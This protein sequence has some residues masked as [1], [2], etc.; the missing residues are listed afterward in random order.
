[1]KLGQ[2]AGL[3]LKT[4]KHFQRVEKGFRMVLYCVGMT[5]QEIN[6]VL[7]AKGPYAQITNWMH[8]EMQHAYKEPPQQSRSFHNDLVLLV[9][10]E[11]D[12]QHQETLS[13]TLEQH[14]A[15][16]VLKGKYTV[17]YNSERSI[18]Q[19]LRIKPDGTLRGIL[20]MFE[21][22]YQNDV[23]YAGISGQLLEIG[24]QIDLEKT[25]Y[26][27]TMPVEMG[28]GIVMVNATAYNGKPINKKTEERNKQ[29]TIEVKVQS[30][31]PLS[32]FTE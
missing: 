27:T 20:T 28:E 6:Q 2:A 22:A 3:L 9:E 15:R 30:E 32:V 8:F 12:S 19:N 4:Q 14:P 24:G 1:M 31:K 13:L 18:F 17:T 26:S 23:P 21:Q 5:G 16:Y 10:K 11:Y 25:T 29:V 7:N